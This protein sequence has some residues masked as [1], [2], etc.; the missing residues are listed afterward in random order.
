MIKKDAVLVIRDLRI[1]VF[2]TVIQ[3]TWTIESGSRERS[4]IGIWTKK[5]Y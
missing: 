3:E 2:E 4:I 1:T 5:K